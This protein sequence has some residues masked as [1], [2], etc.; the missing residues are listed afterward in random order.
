[1]R[2][3]LVGF[4]ACGKTTLGELLAKHQGGYG[5]GGRQQIE[6]DQVEIVGGVRHRK[7]LGGQRVLIWRPPLRD[8]GRG[9]RLAQPGALELGQ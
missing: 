1:M 5:R 3:V 4:M 8:D 7:T 6:R 2:I 9:C